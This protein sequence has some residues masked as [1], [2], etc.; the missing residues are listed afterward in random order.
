MYDSEDL[1]RADSVQAR[2]ELRVD[3]AIRQNI[4][5]F[6]MFRQDSR[7]LIIQRMEGSARNCRRQ[8][9]SAENLDIFALK[10]A[11]KSYIMQDFLV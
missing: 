5:L 2:G 1:L 6:G 3:F 7:A 9:A 10:N 11:K 8:T 4:K